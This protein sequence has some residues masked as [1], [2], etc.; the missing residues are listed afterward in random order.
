MDYPEIIDEGASL[1]FSHYD[2]W[3]MHTPDGSFKFTVGEK[4]FEP[5]LEK[6]GGENA[7]AEWRQLNELLRPIKALAGAVP[8]LT[9]R[10]D[11]G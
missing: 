7:L 6:F 11:P 1:K 8:P 5:I 10:S 2:G 9:L 4:K 3:V